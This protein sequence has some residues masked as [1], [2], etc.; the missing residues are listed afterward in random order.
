VIDQPIELPTLAENIDKNNL[1]MVFFRNMEFG[2]K[3]II[4]FC[5]EKK[6]EFK[7]RH[8][9]DERTLTQKITK[10]LRQKLDFIKFS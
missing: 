5:S 6:R 9:A 10:K 7:L 1:E 4:I 2:S 3:K 8:L